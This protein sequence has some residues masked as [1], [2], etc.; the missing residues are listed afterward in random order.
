VTSPEG[1][2]RAGL[3]CIGVLLLYLGVCYPDGEILN[4]TVP[5]EAGAVAFTRQ[6]P[7]EL[8]WFYI[9]AHELQDIEMYKQA[10][11]KDYR[12]WVVPDT[13]PD[14][15]EI[16]DM[17]WITRASDVLAADSMFSDPIVKAIHLRFFPITDWEPCTAR[18]GADSS[19]VQLIHGFEITVDPLIR[20]EIPTFRGGTAF[21]EISRTS[22][23]I[24]VVP[25]PE[26]PG[27]WVILSIREEWETD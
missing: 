9:M 7:D 23:R 10:L 11:H 17:P 13:E 3:V 4:Q 14:L 2:A 5:S 8:L 1:K 27:S 19:G 26:V 12:Y 24:T 18:L 6:S 15:D 20:L 25:D 22:M 21:K 16:L